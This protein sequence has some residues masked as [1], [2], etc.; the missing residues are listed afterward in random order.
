MARHTFIHD[1]PFN[2]RSDE[3]KNGFM[4][5]DNASFNQGTQGSTRPVPSVFLVL[6]YGFG[7]G[8]LAGF[9]KMRKLR[10]IAPESRL[11]DDPIP[12]P[13]AHTWKIFFGDPH[14]PLPEGLY[15]GGVEGC[16]TRFEELLAL[17]QN[18]RLNILGPSGAV[19]HYAIKKDGKIVQQG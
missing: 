16:R 11:A 10:T 18:G 4:E 8:F 17:T 3:P 14:Q 12:G 13:Q 1:Y 15:V 6:C 2:A 9:S 7:I 5:T 19:I